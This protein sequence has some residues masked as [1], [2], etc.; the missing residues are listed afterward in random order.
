MKR[1]SDSLTRNTKGQMQNVI[2]LVVFLAIF[3]IFVPIGLRITSDL[4][5]A[6]Q[7][8]G[9]IP[10]D[11]KDDFQGVEDR[12][13]LIWDG[14]YAFLLITVFIG[15]F[16]MAFNADSSP[17]FFFFFTAL[18]TLFVFVLPFL[19]NAFDDVST[20]TTFS[21]EGSAFTVIPFVMGNYVALSLVMLGI[22][23]IAFFIR[24]QQV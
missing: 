7:D 17:V 3:A 13:P 9:Q 21:G 1:S 4:N 6:V 19:A 12:Y 23:S 11:F 8:Q 22:V 20:G 24:R 14:F 2:I 5:S 18:L 16:L 10:Q 15:A